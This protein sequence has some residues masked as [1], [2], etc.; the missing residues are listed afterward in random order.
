MDANE[1][2]YDDYVNEDDIMTSALQG[3]NTKTDPGSTMAS[4]KQRRIPIWKLTEEDEIPAMPEVVIEKPNENKCRKDMKDCDD[5]ITKHLENVKKLREQIDA[6][7]FGN[8]PERKKLKETKVALF[9]KLTPITAQINELVAELQPFND[10][11]KACKDIK[12]SL[13]KEIQYKEIEKLDAEI[14]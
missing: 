4:K 13:Q 1:D 7:K 8:N 6:E 3:K 2:Y 5:Q 9:E 11:S 10:E 12:D 14:K